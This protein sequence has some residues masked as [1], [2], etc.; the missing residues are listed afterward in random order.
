MGNDIRKRERVS[1][2]T[3]A[4]ERGTDETTLALKQSSR[5]M[6]LIMTLRHALLLNKCLGQC[7]GEAR[8]HT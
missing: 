4:R 3:K 6:M 2:T 5:V 1:Y 8:D 7:A